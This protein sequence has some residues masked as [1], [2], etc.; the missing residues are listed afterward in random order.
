MVDM[1]NLIVAIQELQASQQTV[2]AN[3][4][5]RRAIQDEIRSIKK[6]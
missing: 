1:E 3:M 4:E 2:L 5:V 6:R